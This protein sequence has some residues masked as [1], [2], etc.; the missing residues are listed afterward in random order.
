MLRK[1]KDAHEQ[2]L[3]LFGRAP[4]TVYPQDAHEAVP[5]WKQARVRSID[6][7]L[8][9]VKKLPSGG[10]F[11]IAATA[12]I[13]D[14]PQPF[15]I[16][17]HEIAVW[18]SARKI[19]A[20]LNRCPH[21]GAPLSEGSVR[22]GVLRCPWHGMRIGESEHGKLLQCH[23]DGVLAWVQLGESEKRD[24][25]T[26]P[27]RPNE[28][29]AGVIRFTARCDPEDIIANRLDPWHGVHFHPHS[30]A[31][32][33]VLKEADDVITV[34]VVFRAFGPIGVE[35]DC[36]FHCPEPN[37]IAMTIIEGEGQG[38]V[39][40]THATPIFPGWTT[41]TEATLATSVRRF[42]KSALRHPDRVRPHIEKRAKGLW[43]EDRAYAERRYHLRTRASF[44]EAST[45]NFSVPVGRPRPI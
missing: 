29:V 26:L 24:R 34:R 43:A 3:W 1:E 33:K 30:F 8:E 14:K 9:R 31:R 17:G 6:A 10:W 21:M 16:D 13:D 32:L 27:V 42:F 35:V 37:T 2:T 12:D 5:D 19:L 40:E 20:V 15:L 22:D 11:V 4:K 25:P 36:T 28:C 39:V 45:P 18:K 7:S 38:S 23:N 41:V 44:G